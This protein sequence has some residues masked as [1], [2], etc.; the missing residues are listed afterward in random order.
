ME[1]IQWNEASEIVDL[2][3]MHIGIMPLKADAWSE[4]KCGFKLIQYLSLGIPAVANPVGVN[5]NIIEN[6]VTGFLCSTV[7]E[8]ENALTKL[9]KD[10]HLR[11]KMGEK[12]RDKIV[13]SYSIQANEGLFLSLFDK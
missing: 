13:S 4:G 12:G 2:L 9:I 6:E 7:E 10:S 8:W 1:F 5:K 11:K 3:E